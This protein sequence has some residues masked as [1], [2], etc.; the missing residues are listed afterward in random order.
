MCEGAIIAM[1][2]VADPLEV[3]SAA[4][5]IT[6]LDAHLMLLTHW[7]ESQQ[8]VLMTETDRAQISMPQVAL[9]LELLV[10]PNFHARL[11]KT[12]IMRICNL[13]MVRHYRHRCQHNVSRGTRS[14][15]NGSRR[16]S[17]TPAPRFT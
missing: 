7:I 5:T 16:Y 11:A 1:Q 6:S 15:M 12:H 4:G 10:Q 9:M 8:H 3:S 13:I 17:L 2:P 14:L